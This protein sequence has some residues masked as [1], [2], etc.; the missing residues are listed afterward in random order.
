MGVDKSEAEIW[1]GQERLAASRGY[2]G[3]TSKNNIITSIRRIDRVFLPIHLP[4]NVKTGA[5]CAFAAASCL[6]SLSPSL[7]I[8]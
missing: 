2:F 7:W 3:G 8:S 5:T 1:S 4:S 6:P